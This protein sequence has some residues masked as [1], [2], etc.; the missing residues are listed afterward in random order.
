[1][2]TVSL[3][4]ILIVVQAI[5][6]V[7][8]GVSGSKTPA[9]TLTW[10]VVCTLLPLIGFCIYA[11]LDGQIP[12]RRRLEWRDPS[13][14][15]SAPSGIA[16]DLST[17]LGKFTSPIREAEVGL[18]F[19][20]DEF[21]TRLLED[22]KRAKRTIDIEFYTFRCDEVGGPILD[23]LLERAS[24]GVKVRFVRDGMGSLDF[25]KEAVQKMAEAGVESRVF[26]PVRFP[27]LRRTL[28][29]RDH[30]KLVVVDEATGYMGGMNVG[31]EYTGRKDGVGTW[32]DTQSRITGQAVPL[33]TTLFETNWDISTPETKALPRAVERIR[34][35][36]VARREMLSCTVEFA[37]ESGVDAEWVVGGGPTCVPLYSVGTAMQFLDSGPDHSPA[38]RDAFF[39]CIT[40]AQKNIRITTP[41]FLPGQ[42]LMT[43]LATA[44]ARG[45]RVQLLIPERVDHRWI[46]FACQTYYQSLLDAGLEVY[47]W[48][49]GVLHAK[50]M[51]VDDEVSIVGAA[52][53]DPRSLRLNYE[54]CFISYGKELSEILRKQFHRDLDHARRLTMRDVEVGLW[55]HTINHAA[56][57]VSP[58]L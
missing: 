15:L 45:V 24:C 36:A 49:P 44:A 31:L 52:N 34:P 16:H 6:L 10:M 35:H 56:R 9:R 54:Q 22:L 48:Q 28:N 50:L 43:A 26:F 5:L 19:S 29:H 42:D 37:A 2:T 55:Q 23:V 25:P 13:K 14:S 38:V 53:Y 39:L 30:C 58:M 12:K 4:A 41:Y 1:M 33:L 57:L 8:L 47:L 51:T 7:A 32:R 11:I 27:Y 3:L 18:I 20:G 21:Y 40:R 46:G 17:G